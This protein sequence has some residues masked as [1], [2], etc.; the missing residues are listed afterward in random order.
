MKL[1]INFVFYIKKQ[2]EKI[3]KIETALFNSK[4][5]LEQTVLTIVIVALAI[6]SQVGTSIE[7]RLTNP[8]LPSVNFAMVARRE[9]PPLPPNN[10]ATAISSTPTWAQQHTDLPRAKAMNALPAPSVFTPARPQFYNTA[11]SQKTQTPLRVQASALQQNVLEKQQIATEQNESP[12]E[13]Q[14][15]EIIDDIKEKYPDAIVVLNFRKDSDNLSGTND[16][17]I[18]GTSSTYEEGKKI[19]VLLGK[20]VKGSNGMLTFST[21]SQIDQ[22]HVIISPLLTGFEITREKA[23]TLCLPK[24]EHQ[25]QTLAMDYTL[26]THI[27]YGPD[28]GNFYDFADILREKYCS[29]IIER[30]APITNNIYREELE[31]NNVTVEDLLKG[32]N[33]CF[34]VDIQKVKDQGISEKMVI[35]LSHV[36]ISNTQAVDD[37]K[38]FVNLL[39]DCS[40]KSPENLKVIQKKLQAGVEKAIIYQKHYS[41]IQ[42]YIIPGTIEAKEMEYAHTEFVRGVEA[43]VAYARATNIQVSSGLMNDFRNA[44]SMGNVSLSEAE[45]LARQNMRLENVKNGAPVIFYSKMKL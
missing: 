43:T 20:K 26:P 4:L 42:P 41:G 22:D 23:S 25:A 10:F 13:K 21:R 34:D 31:R 15:I 14:L 11:L 27:G 39:R 18:V 36:K 16:I 8:V 24:L 5:S 40:D 32:A 9:T 19:K 17:T 12:I 1:L 6:S 33:H 30:H 38:R 3:I 37:F 45:R 35:P 7:R 28:V 29:A 44:E 2:I